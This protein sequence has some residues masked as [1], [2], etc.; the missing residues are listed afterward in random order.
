MYLK[1]GT[2][3]EGKKGKGRKGKG[4]GGSVYSQSGIRVDG[5]LRHVTKEGF[6]S[7]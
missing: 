3:G 2:V 6:P 4:V 5:T 7:K 1:W